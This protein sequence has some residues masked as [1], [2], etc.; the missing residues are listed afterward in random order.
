MQALTAKQRRKAASEYSKKLMLRCDAVLGGGE[1]GD[2][3]QVQR[4][5][6]RMLQK[7][8]KLRVRVASY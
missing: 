8:H 5:S 7:R 1:G 4:K 3:Q 6:V 2:G